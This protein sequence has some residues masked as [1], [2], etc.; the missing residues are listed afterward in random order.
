MLLLHIQTYYL[1]VNAVYSKCINGN[2]NQIIS[3]QILF[4]LFI[5][6]IMKANHL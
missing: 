5:L 4:S 3:I 1:K 6:K 2:Y